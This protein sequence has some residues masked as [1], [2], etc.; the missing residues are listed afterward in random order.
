MLRLTLILS[1]ATVSVAQGGTYTEPST[2]LRFPDRL[3]AWKKMD[4][5]S[6]PQKELGVSI[7]YQHPVAGS[8]HVY[9]YSKGLRKIPTGG[10]NAIVR[11]EFAAVEQEIQGTTAQFGY[12]NVKKL[13][14]ATPEI[15][16]DGKI[17][18]LLAVAYSFEEPN[19]RPPNRISYALLTGYRNR[20][21]KLRFTLPGDFEKTPERGLSE[22]KDLVFAFVE[23]NQSNAAGFW[24]AAI[25]ERST[26]RNKRLA[27]N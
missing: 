7:S 17:A 22:L 5:T 25:D 19:A 13:L 16:H 18:T 15:K 9:I 1:L 26:T 27:A 3:G 4:V 2:K 11:K 14:E 12:Q 24:Q 6:F 8:A 23:A 10:A 20:F 21:V